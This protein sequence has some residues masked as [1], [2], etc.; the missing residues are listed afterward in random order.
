MLIFIKIIL[1]I[2]IVTFFVPAIIAKKEKYTDICIKI[3]MW[4]FRLF[5]GI[6]ILFGLSI[7]VWELFR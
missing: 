3:M 1:V 6:M 4:S 5:M 7:F 2:F